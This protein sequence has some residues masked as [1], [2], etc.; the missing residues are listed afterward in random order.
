MRLVL[1]ALLLISSAVAAAAQV[2]P[3]RMKQ[4]SG[5]AA[6]ESAALRE[7]S[8]ALVEMLRNRK[9]VGQ[10]SGV[11]PGAVVKTV[12]PAAESRK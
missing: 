12:P 8:P 10:A 3:A 4:Q 2:E 5:R 7:M 1:S 6:A 9:A 11:P